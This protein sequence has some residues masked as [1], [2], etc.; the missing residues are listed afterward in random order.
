MQKNLKKKLLIILPIV[1][2]LIVGA[3]AIINKNKKTTE[4]PAQVSTKKKISSPVNV[5]A[6]SE[7]P[8]MRLE[9]NANGHYITI[10]IEEVKKTAKELNY[11]MEYQTGSMLQGFGGLISLGKLPISEK[12]L[13]GSQSAG[14]AIT[15]HEDIKGGNF[16]AEFSGSESYAVKSAWRYFQNN[17]KATEFTSQDTKFTISNA[18]LANYSYVIIYNSP[19]YPGELKSEL[20]SDPYVVTAEKSLKTISSNFTVSFRSSEAGQI[21]GY[22]GSKWQK[23]DSTHEDGIVKASGALMDVYVLTKS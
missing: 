20:L 8:Y 2:L 12:K 10:V 6:V 1:L 18:S 23:M 3:V 14:G 17:L 22:D 19:G 16:L 5:I 9:P 11:E 7:R 21:M 4:Q 15:Y 13:F